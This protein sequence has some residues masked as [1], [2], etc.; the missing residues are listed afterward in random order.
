MPGT[1]KKSV[2][3][4]LV[5]WLTHVLLVIGDIVDHVLDRILNEFDRSIAFPVAAEPV[6]AL[7]EGFR[8][9]K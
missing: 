1:I 9:H 6:F 4:S 8:F 3:L 2:K 7:S 5:K